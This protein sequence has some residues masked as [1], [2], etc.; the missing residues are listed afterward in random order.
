MEGVVEIDTASGWTAAF[1]G[2]TLCDGD[3]IRSSQ[4]G[5]AS[6]QVMD[7]T[8]LR[9]APHSAIQLRAVHS[10]TDSL[11]D[12]VVKV[13]KGMI[14]TISRDPR[15]LSI[16]TPFVNAGIEGTEFVVQVEPDAANVSVLEGE[17][18][19]ATVLEREGERVSGR[20]L[21]EGDEGVVVRLD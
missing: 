9:V 14:H 16:D 15:S 1:P 18:A 7:G 6:V 4:F 5:R 19:C 3:I 2:Q 20:L 12:I 10:G 21:L 11:Y 17:I 8:L 13:L